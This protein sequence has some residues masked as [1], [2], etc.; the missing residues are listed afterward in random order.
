METYGIINGVSKNL[1]AEQGSLLKYI[2]I[3]NI[4]LSIN[5]WKSIQRGLVK[6]KSLDTLRINLVEVNRE[7]L[8]CLSEGMKQNT[9]VIRLDLGYN[10]IKDSDGDVLAR[11]VSN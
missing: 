3:A 10:N 1:Q 7:A 4:S 8:L 2:H 5:S 6:T 11:I 9:S